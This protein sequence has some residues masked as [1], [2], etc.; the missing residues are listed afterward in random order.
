MPKFDEIRNAVTDLVSEN[1]AYWKKIYKVM[2]IF[3][4]QLREY[5]GVTDGAVVDNIG[6][7]HALFSTGIYD[8]SDQKI[9]PKAPF[10]F[11]REG[12][13]LCFDL[14]LN[15]P[16]S[17]NNQIVIRKVINIKFKYD[18]GIYL[19]EAEGVPSVTSCKEID[20]GVELTPFFEALHAQLIK[21]LKFAE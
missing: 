5:W 20:D 19:F 12:K 9:E 3:N 13:K 6:N 1:D 16:S 18:N 21:S 17:D 14:L 11:P 10:M 7:K 4:S 8:E 2:M 15:L